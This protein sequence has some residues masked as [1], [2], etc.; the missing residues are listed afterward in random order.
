[1]S[2][3]ATRRPG[4]PRVDG[5]V[6][7]G[8]EPVRDAFL[9][10]LRERGEVG[11]AFAVTRDG[12][13]VVDLWGGLADPE[14]GRPWRR[15]TLQAIFSGTK[16]LVA[17]CLLMLADRGRLDL[18][19]PVARYWPEFAANGKDRVRVV[20]LASHR[21]ALPGV[22]GRLSPDEVLDPRHVA[23][24]LAA[25]AQETDP[26]AAVTYHP[27]TYGWL[28]GELVRRVDG[29]GIGRFFAEEVA[30][31]L[32][33]EIWIG[34]PARLEPRVSRL[35]HGPDWGRRNGWDDAAFAA[36]ELLRRI[37]GNPELFGRGPIR[38]NE[39]RWHQAEIPGAGA[40]ATARSMA[41]LYGCLALGGE[42]DGVRLLDRATL[43]RGRRPVSDRFDPIAG[44]R[45]VFGVGFELQ[46]DARALGPPDDAFGHC[47]AG[48]SVH[49]AWPSLRAG[50]SY[51]MNQ[52]RDD[53]RVDARARALLDATHE[54]LA[55]RAGGS[56]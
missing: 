27:L 35:V 46:T 22:A 28:C 14:R 6:A 30:D 18:E 48:G 4:A 7:P 16:G 43:E 56:G 44:D 25:Q 8:F 49:A 33:L 38:W 55:R 45:Q 10:N 15:D 36:D 40:I 31:P 42:L 53:A 3:E 24:L 54:V 47:G 9:A 5:F 39:P 13:P 23:S 29:R 11:A 21:A 34:L 19:A 12:E 50:V 1:M 17:L 41:R 20:D 32:G 2:G 52:M 37:W 51:A 26:R